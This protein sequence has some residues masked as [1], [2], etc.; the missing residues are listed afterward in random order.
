MKIILFSSGSG[1]TVCFALACS[2]INDVTPCIC[3]GS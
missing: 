1:V 3:D 2:L